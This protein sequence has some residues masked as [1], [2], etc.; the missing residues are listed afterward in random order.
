MD[1]S[2]AWRRERW[3]EEAAGFLP[4]WAFSL[5]TF[6]YLYFFLTLFFLAALCAKS[7]LSSPSRDRTC[8][9]SIGST[10]S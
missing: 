8:A 6:V 3:T 4:N 5:L 1:T 7:D 2:Q 10:E 9:P